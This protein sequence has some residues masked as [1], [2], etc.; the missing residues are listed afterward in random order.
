MTLLQGGMSVTEGL[1]TNTNSTNSTKMP[2]PPRFKNI[3]AKS[4]STLYGKL[5]EL[6]K[7]RQALTQVADYDLSRYDSYCSEIYD[8][9]TRRKLDKKHD[10]QG[11]QRGRS[12]GKGV[13]MR[14]I[15]NPSPSPITAV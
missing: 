4:T 13:E 2:V 14:K 8:V 1:Y 15:H 3:E 9:L 6:G 5:D 10:K 11:K 7:Q 12:R